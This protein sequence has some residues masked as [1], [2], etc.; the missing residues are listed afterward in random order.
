MAT[1]SGGDDIIPCPV[2]IFLDYFVTS[3]I[4][5]NAVME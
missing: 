2:D 4:K 3:S 5:G 1:A